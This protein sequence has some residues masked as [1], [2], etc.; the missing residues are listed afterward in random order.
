MKNGLIYENDSLIYYKDDIP[1]HAG[2][3]KVDGDIYYIGTGGRAVK[4][5]HIVHRTMG[6]NILKRGTYTFGDDYKLVEGSYVAPKRRYSTR[7]SRQR[8]LVV[9]IITLTSLLLL[10]SLYFAESRYGIFSNTNSEPLKSTGYAF[11]TNMTEI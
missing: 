11:S 2:A 7:K 4:G 1:C 9:W 3:L 5:V 8:K 10:A 6:N